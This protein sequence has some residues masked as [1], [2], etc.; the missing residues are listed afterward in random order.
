MNT[1]EDKIV[2]TN[3]KDKIIDTI[4]L[5]FDG[6]TRPTNPGP[7]GIG[8]YVLINNIPHTK[9]SKFLGHRTNN[10]A[11]YSAL[12]NGLNT[13]LNIPDSNI[14]N[15]QVYGDSN[16]VIQ[17]M[18]G[19]WKVKAKNLESL[20]FEAQRISKMFKRVTFNHIPRN[21]NSI[22]DALANS[23]IKI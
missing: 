7:S 1:K 21:K 13:I 5:Y 6:S 16:L 15:I 23:S 2:D 18:K 22:A 20:N 19:Q 12:I 17:Q 10:E 11:E 4:Q 14:A 9:G 3:Y 8:F